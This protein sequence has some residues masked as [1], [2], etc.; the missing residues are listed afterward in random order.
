MLHLSADKQWHSNIT[1]SSTRTTLNRLVCGHKCNSSAETCC[2]IH[3]RSRRV[4]FIRKVYTFLL[5]KVNSHVAMFRWM[6]SG[7][8]QC[9]R[10][11]YVETFDNQY[12]ILQT[13]FWDTW[14]E[15]MS[16]AA[17]YSLL[18]FR[19]SMYKI[20]LLSVDKT[21]DIYDS[22]SGLIRSLKPYATY[23]PDFQNQICTEY[24]SW[25]NSTAATPV[26]SI[27]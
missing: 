25:E 17:L 6:G 27:G 26:S 9:L 14:K 12:I 3:F 24:P 8:N 23:L 19:W 21:F 22:F 20:M 15:K 7:V 10:F 2:G 1:T 13:L 11:N 18:A 5:L 16:W 4:F